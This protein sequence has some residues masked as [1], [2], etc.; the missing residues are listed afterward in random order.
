MHA[1][2]DG[3]VRHVLV[4]QQAHQRCRQ[5][6]SSRGRAQSCVPLLGWMSYSIEAEFLSSASKSEKM[7]LARITYNAVDGALNKSRESSLS[8]AGMNERGEKATPPWV[9]AQS[10]PSFS[11]MNTR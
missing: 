5:G 8:Q 7:R 11:I 2:Y 10:H 4:K 3:C 1:L 9:W 6:D